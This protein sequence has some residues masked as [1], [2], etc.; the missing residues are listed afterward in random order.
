[1]VIVPYDDKCGTRVV[2]RNIIREL[3]IS[4]PASIGVEPEF[5]ISSIMDTSV[6]ASRRVRLIRS[7]KP[8]SGIEPLLR[9]GYSIVVYQ[10]VG[11]S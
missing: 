2:N 1:M 10:K 6:V 7:G 11:S 5:V 4:E 9:Y 3:R 8:T